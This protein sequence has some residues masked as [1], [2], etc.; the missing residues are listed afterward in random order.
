MPR[1]GIE[2][3]SDD[4]LKCLEKIVSAKFT[5]ACDYAKTFDTKNRWHS[6]IKSNQLLRIMNAIRATK[7]V[8]KI[9]EQRW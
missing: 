9:K 4:D 1:N 2:S 3:L 8:R 5:E 6:N 7:T